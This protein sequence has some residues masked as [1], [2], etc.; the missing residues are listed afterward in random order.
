MATTVDP[1]TPTM[2]TAL[3]IVK[4]ALCAVIGFPIGKS[5][6]GSRISEGNKARITVKTGKAE[7][8][9]AA[10]M[11]KVVDVVNEAIA[12]DQ[13]CFRLTMPRKDAESTYGSAMYDVVEPPAQ[14]EELSL[15]YIEGLVLHSQLHP[16]LPSTG[17]VGKVSVTKQKFRVN[18]Q[19]LEVM[20]DVEPS[21]DTPTD[22]TATPP[23][24]VPPSAETVVLLNASEARVSADDG[25]EGGV[26]ESGKAAAEGGQKVTPWE[27]EADG[28]VDY[29]KL[30]KSFGSSLITEDIVA[31]VERVT[32]R[33]AHRFLRRGLFFS[34]RDLT[35]ILDL[36]EAG[37][38]FFLYTGRGP[39]SDAL[40]LGHLVPF[41][42]T[43]YL[44][45]AFKVPLVVQLTDDEKFLFKPELKLEECHRLAFENAKDII[46]CGFDPESTFIFSDLDYIQHMYPVVLKIQKL[47]TYNQVRGIFG[48][49]ESHNIGCQAFPAVQAAPSFSSSFPIP[50]GGTPDRPCLIPCAIDQ[51]AYFRMTRDVAPRMKLRKPALIHS[52]FFPG[53]QGPGGKMSSSTESSAIFVTDTPKK[54]KKKINGCFSGGQETKEL[55]ELHG[56]NIHVDVPYQYLTF[57]MEDDDELK[58][59][60]E[61]Y[62][63]GR[64]LTGEVKKILIEILT[65]MTKDH[66][67]ARAAVT[68]E[69]VRSFMAVRPI[70]GSGA[71]AGNVVPPPP[72]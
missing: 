64:M 54:V 56:A 19:E 22:D 1:R 67:D 57:F 30:V 69:M 28:E 59:I 45:E 71:A 4:G 44:Q 24:C 23:Q 26:E 49:T 36:Y 38:K 39:S 2:T 18:K 41:H 50:L 70:D 7:A 9:T 15:L 21:T 16:C 53:L 63:A 66:Q 51:D 20:F 33:K 5:T 37:K 17:P 29:E 60:G 11:Q 68:D 61:E 62:A 52:R 25:V 65:K 3:E 58:R 40:H 47:V 14:V 31:R 43:K 46:A 6:I 32:G 55:Q 13:A 10:Q 27:V 35:Q 48:F 42:F 8:P 72:P 34:H 12:K